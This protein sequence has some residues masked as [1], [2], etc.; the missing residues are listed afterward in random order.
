MRRGLAAAVARITI[1]VCVLACVMG[2]GCASAPAGE[3][4]RPEVVS[5]TKAVIY[6][7]SPVR[8]GLARR[9]VRVFMNQQP[10]GTLSPGQ[11]LARTVDAGEYLVRVESESSM[12]KAVRVLAGDAAYLAVRVPSAGKPVLEEPESAVARDQIARTTR[13]AE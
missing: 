9:T 12:V 2:S 4:F 7:Y 5:S 6:V 1:T 10:I 8:G 11:Y 13:I 3:P